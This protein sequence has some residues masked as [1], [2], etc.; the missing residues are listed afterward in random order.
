MD[1]RVSKL[2]AEVRQQRARAD[3]NYQKMLEAMGD[4]GF[5][6]RAMNRAGEGIPSDDQPKLAEL[7]EK[8]AG[9]I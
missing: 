7:N 3:L 9:K 5:T 1:E 6:V 4:L 8:W 2:E